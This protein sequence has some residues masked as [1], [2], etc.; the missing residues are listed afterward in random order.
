MAL[1][2]LTA[3]N[4]QSLLCS[5]SIYVRITLLIFYTVIVLFGICLNVVF[6]MVV[7]KQVYIKNI[8]NS[9]VILHSVICVWGLIISII[10][11]G[12]LILFPD[13]FQKFNLCLSSSILQILTASTIFHVALAITIYRSM[14]VFCNRKIKKTKS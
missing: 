6:L 12:S 9:G 5:T 13:L 8:V 11:C 1:R 3:M 4:C 14:L 10:V 2:E 7:Q